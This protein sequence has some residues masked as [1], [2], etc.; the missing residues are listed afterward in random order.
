ME[1]FATKV[2]SAKIPEG[3]VG[4]FF[5]GQAGFVF[6]TPQNTLIAVDPYLSDCCNR[7]FGFKRLMPY[8]LE[9]HELEFDI[10]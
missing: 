10:S 5:L 1:N 2:L 8:I 9:A 6:K 4:V 3:E 7:Y